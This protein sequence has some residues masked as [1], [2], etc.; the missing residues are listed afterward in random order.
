MNWTIA[1]TQTFGVEIEMNGITR[2][3]AATLAADFFGTNLSRYTHATN[4]YYTFSAWDSQGREW[5]FARDVSIAGPDDE[6]CEMV[7]PILTYD[8]MEMLQ[9][10]VRR[11]RRAGAVSNPAQGCGVHIHIGANADTEGGHNGKSL[12]NLVNMMSSHEDLLIKA[13][14][15][16][17]SRINSYC[18][19][20]F[21]PFADALNSAKPKTAAEVQDIW[22]KANGEIH[23]KNVT[24]GARATHYYGSRYRMLNLHSLFRTKTVEFRLFQFANPD[25]EKKN[26]LHAGELKAYI[27]LALVL[28][29]QA[30]ESRSVSATPVQLDNEKFAMRTWMNRMGMI[31][32]EFKTAREHLCKRLSGDASFRYNNRADYI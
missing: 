20:V 15:I 11:L 24:N 21:R 17:P 12:R 8:D 7:T 23:P 32:D 14:G 31:G 26:G 3:K 18:H 13:V 5:K 25:A 10:L 19:K 2:M 30:K 22:Y 9:E 27:Q 1:K 29:Q 6:K 4:G 16:A 28:S